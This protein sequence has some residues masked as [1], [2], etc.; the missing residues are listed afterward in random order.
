MFSPF[1]IIR[2]D[3]ETVS[4]NAD[5]NIPGNG[6]IGSAKLFA[7]YQ[8]DHVGY[9]YTQHRNV[10]A[11]QQEDFRTSAGHVQPVVNERKQPVPAT[12]CY[13]GYQMVAT[14]MRSSLFLLFLCHRIT[15]PCWGLV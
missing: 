3:E 4:F 13:A 12:D 9:R 7:S 5:D 15:L 8:P 1:L 10:N 2:Y 6:Q 14:T 11:G